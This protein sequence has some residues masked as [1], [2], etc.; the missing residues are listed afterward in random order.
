MDYTLREVF[1]AADYIPFG[2]L[3]SKFNDRFPTRA[4][5]VSF[6]RTCA[7]LRNLLIHDQKTPYLY[8]AIPSAWMV[9][10]FDAITH[11]MQNPRRVLPIFKCD[12]YK[13][14]LN[15]KLISVLDTIRDKGYSQFPVYEGI[16]FRGL[17]T[18]N[19]ITRW[20]AEYVRKE[21]I[22]DFDDILVEHA[23]RNEENRVDY[24]FIDGET[25]ID[26]VFTKFAEN[27]YLEAT[28]ISTNACRT[29]EPIGII[30]RW[31]IFQEQSSYSK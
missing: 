3:I 18:E 14:Q 23:F 20:L 19:G 25:L 27:P 10:R 22:F 11:S 9:E 4:K 16:E 24:D 28:L 17:L 13:L 6:L 8:P 1:K 26:D 30:T 12:V 2:E 5:D 31:N 29:D 21:S 7:K 15:Q